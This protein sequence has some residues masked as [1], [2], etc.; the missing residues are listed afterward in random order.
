MEVMTT[1]DKLL[2]Q[3]DIDALLG[4]AGLEG[5]YDS[6]KDIDQKPKVPVNKSGVHFCN[7]TEDEVQ[8]TI[9]FLLSKA[10][11]DRAE[12]LKIIWNAVGTIPMAAGFDMIIQDIEYE[13]LGV[14]KDNHLV[15]KQKP[16]E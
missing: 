12:D 11:L 5:G 9:S 13:S 3:D 6:D 1:G 7:V 10:L 2:A 8:D 15:V 14:L 4:Q 16:V